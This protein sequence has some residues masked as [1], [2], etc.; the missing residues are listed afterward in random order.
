MSFFCGT[1]YFD[2]GVSI[3][4][5]SGIVLYNIHLYYMNKNNLNSHKH[6]FFYGSQIKESL[7]CAWTW[8]WVNYFFIIIMFFNPFKWS[9]YGYFDVMLTQKDGVLFIVPCWKCII[10][11][12]NYVATIHSTYFRNS[13]EECESCYSKHS[14]WEKRYWQWPAQEKVIEKR[15]KWQEKQWKITHVVCSWKSRL[16]F[17][18]LAFC[19]GVE[20]RK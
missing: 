1:R 2:I 16:M 3:Q 15:I 11:S 13:T 6:I 7:K 17:A 20:V 4:W 18:T 19:L 10:V 9:N 8:G 5:K 14:L 12:Y